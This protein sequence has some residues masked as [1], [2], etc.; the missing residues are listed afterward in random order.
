MVGTCPGLIVAGLRGGS[1]KTLLTMSLIAC[2]KAG[3]R[4]VVPF[5][6]GPDYIDAAWLAVA[7]GRPCYNLDPYLMSPEQIL[8]SY[9]RRTEAAQ[10]AVVEGNRGLFDGVDEHGT[11]STA[12]LAKL[13]G[14]PVVVVLDV[15]KTTRTAAAMVLGLRAMDPELCI[16]GVVLNQVGNSRHES[17][18]RKSVEHYGGVEVL[19]ALPRLRD[20]GLPERHLGLVPPPEKGDVKAVLERAAQSV[21]RHVE[22]DALWDLAQKHTRGIPQVH[23]YRAKRQASRGRARLGVIRD[24]AFHFYYP[25]NLEALEDAGLEL[26]EIDAIKDTGLP[27]VDGLYMGGGFPE[28]FA[29]ALAD[30]QGLRREIRSLAAEGLPI[31]AECGGLM[32]LGEGIRAAGRSYPMVGAL[33]LWTEFTDR[34]QGHG[35]TALEAVVENPFIPKGDI[36][37]GHEFH[38]SRVV[39]LEESKVEFA[40]AVKRGKGLDGR[41]DGIMRKN[42]LASY[43]HLHAVSREDWAWRLAGC[44]VARKASAQRSA[45]KALP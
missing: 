5:K 39:S 31:Y 29:S 26:V 32:Y 6:K 4:L 12:E 40:F 3:G 33:P 36:L 17:V 24:A 18:I 20:L 30:N 21:S 2:W 10:G 14:L 44:A 42:I 35:Y 27:E 45:L 1:G 25:E 11:F 7:S 22:V 13:L 19:G 38:Y 41:R 15:T 37:R 34:P 43:T 16:A 9:A 28:M 8:A 23:L